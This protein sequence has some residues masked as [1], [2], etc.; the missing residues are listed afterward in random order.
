MLDLNVEYDCFWESDYNDTNGI[1]NWLQK[2][3]LNIAVK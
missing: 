1:S 3:L 2:L